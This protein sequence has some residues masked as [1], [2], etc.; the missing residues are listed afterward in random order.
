M[1][2]RAEYNKD[3]FEIT[4]GQDITPILRANYIMRKDALNGWTP[5][6]S[7]KRIGSIPSLILYEYLKKYP[8]LKE[9]DNIQ[10]HRVLSKIFQDHPE[11]RSSGGR[12]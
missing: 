7:M 10:Q 3:N 9:G 8:E 11:F 1:I 2:I 5:D 6:R 4:H 12:F